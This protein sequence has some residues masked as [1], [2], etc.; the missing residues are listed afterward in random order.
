MSVHIAQQ[1][2]AAKCGFEL[3]NHEPYSRNLHR[4]TSVS[5][6]EILLN[7]C[8]FQRDY[9]IIHA[10]EENLEAQDVTFFS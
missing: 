7:I 6:N 10:V 8:H 9:E 2:E 5:Q 1:A 3:L 4:L